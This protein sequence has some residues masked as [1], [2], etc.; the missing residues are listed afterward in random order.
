MQ[1]NLWELSSLHPVISGSLSLC[2][3]HLYG[4]D[5]CLPAERPKLQTGL[6]SCLLSSSSLFIHQQLC[7][8]LRSSLLCTVSVKLRWHFMALCTLKH[9]QIWKQCSLKPTARD[10]LQIFAS[11]YSSP[12]VLV[13]KE[14]TAHENAQFHNFRRWERQKERCP[15]WDDS[16]ENY[17]VV[18]PAKKKKRDVW[19]EDK[20]YWCH[21][22]QLTDRIPSVT[23][24]S[25]TCANSFK[26]RPLK[27]QNQH[28]LQGEKHQY[29]C[30]QTE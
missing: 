15:L 11:N 2:T 17:R 6:D 19:W 12:S 18:S 27:L 22:H 14:Q 30:F 23:A 7:G 24:P 26:K 28:W 4:N 3:H 9:C 13:K 21:P 8:V 25:Q 29:L 20:A 5:L 1:I 16:S 10:P